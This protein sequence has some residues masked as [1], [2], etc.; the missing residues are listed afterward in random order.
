MT[1]AYTE[2][3]EIDTAA[4]RVVG[5]TAGAEPPKRRRIRE[6]YGRAA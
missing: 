5:T 3:N 6:R 1:Q 2:S 4:M